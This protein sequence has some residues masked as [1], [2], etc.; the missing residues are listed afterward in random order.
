MLALAGFGVMSAAET[1]AA[2]VKAQ[3]YVAMQQPAVMNGEAAY[4]D[5]PNL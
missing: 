3:N 2:G 4:R 5:R 1:Q